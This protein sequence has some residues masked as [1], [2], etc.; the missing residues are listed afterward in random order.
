MVSSVHHRKQNGC[1]NSHRKPGSGWNYE[2]VRWET[3]QKNNSNKQKINRKLKGTTTL[4]VKLLSFLSHLQNTRRGESTIS[5]KPMLYFCIG[6][7]IEKSAAPQSTPD[8]EG[9]G[10]DKGTTERLDYF[11]RGSPQTKGDIQKRR[12]YYYFSFRENKSMT[13][14]EALLCAS[15]PQARHGERWGARREERSSRAS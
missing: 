5:R 14:F 13:L 1:Y 6:P 7:N 4:P 15:C 9:D 3:E 8:T 11:V 10:A 2:Q 12:K